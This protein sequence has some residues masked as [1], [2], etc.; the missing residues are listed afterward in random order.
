MKLI[1]GLGNPGNNYS[2][3]KHNFGFWVADELAKQR[4]LKFSSGKGEYVLAADNQCL[5][6][7]PTTFVNNS[8]LAIKHILKYYDKI[9]IEDLLIIY[10]DIDIELGDIR[11]K[12]HG[13]DGGHK[14]VQSI[15]YHLNTDS[16][17]RLKIGIGTSLKMRPSESYVL[18]PFPKK[19]H[20]KIEEV[21]ENALS[22]I[23]FYFDNN[24]EMTMNHFN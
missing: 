20:K 3:T 16:F 12:Q 2:L 19:F 14:G 17:D 11:F 9:D 23:N 13:S 21:I 15:I 24:I 7:K 6:V 1:V 8:G 4:S 10:D 18:K 22:G 5:I